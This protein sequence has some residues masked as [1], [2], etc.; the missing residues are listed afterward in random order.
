MSARK[1]VKGLKKMEY[2]ERLRRLKMTTLENRRLRG[3]MIETWKILSGR[4]DTY[5]S[6]FFQMAN[7]SH[8]LREHSIRLYTM[9]NRFDLRRYSFSQRVVKHWNHLPQHVIETPSLNA[10]KNRFDKFSDMGN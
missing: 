8:N 6:Q 2:E 9:R 3:D 5:S 4:E 7:C 1:I 10:F